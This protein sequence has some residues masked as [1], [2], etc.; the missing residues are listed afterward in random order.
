MKKFKGPYVADIQDFLV[1]SCNPERL[2]MNKAIYIYPEAAL[3]N[4]YYR[5]IYIH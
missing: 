3:Y 1:F 4:Q 5:S 2:A